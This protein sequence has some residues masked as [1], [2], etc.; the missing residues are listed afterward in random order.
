M[1]AASRV[2]ASRHRSRR[3]QSAA[4]ARDAATH[5]IVG[6]GEAFRIAKEEMGTEKRAR[7]HAAAA[8]D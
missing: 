7:A 4:C 1:C 6:M 2:C 3:R 5:Q 8:P